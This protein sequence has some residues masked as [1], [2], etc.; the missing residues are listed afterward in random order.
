MNFRRRWWNRWPWQWL[1]HQARFCEGAGMVSGFECQYC[2]RWAEKRLDYQ[3]IE[4]ELDRA[5]GEE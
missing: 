3:E 5:M 4:G 1:R 2:R